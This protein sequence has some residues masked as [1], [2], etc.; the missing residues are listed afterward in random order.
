MSE[1]HGAAAHATCGR[2]TIA[3]YR[4]IVRSDIRDIDQHY[5]YKDYYYS[6]H[7]SLRLENKHER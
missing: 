2:K 1:L 4:G 7:T 6:H 3:E 5:G